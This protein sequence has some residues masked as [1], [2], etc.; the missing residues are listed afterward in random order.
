MDERLMKIVTYNGGNRSRSQISMHLL[1]GSDFAIKCFTY[2][3]NKISQR[4]F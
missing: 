2:L 3:R 1:Y 4:N